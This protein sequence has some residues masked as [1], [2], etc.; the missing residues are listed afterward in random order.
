MNSSNPICNFLWVPVHFSHSELSVNSFLFHISHS[1]FQIGYYLFFFC[2]LF[3]LHNCQ[4]Q[5]PLAAGL[6]VVSYQFK[7]FQQLT[8][9]VSIHLCLTSVCLQYPRFG[10]VCLRHGAAGWGVWREVQGAEITR[11]YLDACSWW[12]HPKAK[13][14]MAVINLCT[15]AQVVIGEL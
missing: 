11:V 15:C 9:C 5:S 12:S 8:V 6:M 13:V 2:Q 7:V 3:S 10:G 14:Q 4:K 1:V